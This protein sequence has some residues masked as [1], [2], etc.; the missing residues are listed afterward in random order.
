MKASIFGT[1]ENG[2]LKCN[3]KTFQAI[4]ESFNGKRIEISFTKARKSRSN[5]QNRYYW[6]CLIPILKS[7][8]K[9]LGNEFTPEQVH[10]MLKYK[11]LKKD[12]HVKDGEFITKITSSTEL[13]TSEFMD[14]IADIQRWSAEF[15]GVEIP[16]PN[17]QLEIDL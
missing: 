15:F 1:V 17:E 14:Y 6:G 5:Q 16:D 13:S 2:V 7:T 10:D 3:R 9:D 8:L 4:V 12:V 11:F